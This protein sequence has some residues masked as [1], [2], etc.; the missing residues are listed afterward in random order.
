MSALVKEELQKDDNNAPLY[1][2]RRHFG[3]A[4]ESEAPYDVVIL[5]INHKHSLEQHI[6]K[7]HD[8][9]DGIMLYAPSWC[10]DIVT[11]ELWEVYGE[12]PEYSTEELEAALPLIA[13]C[14]S[15]K[16]GWDVRFK[17]RYGELPDAWTTADDLGRNTIYLYISHAIS[18]LNY[19]D[20]H[21][22]A[23]TTSPWRQD[24]GCVR[25]IDEICHEYGHTQRKLHH[26][27]LVGRTIEEYKADWVADAIAASG[28]TDVHALFEAMKTATGGKVNELIETSLCAPDALGSF[29]S[30]FA[31]QYGLRALYLLMAYAPQHYRE[32]SKLDTYVDLS[33]QA[34][35]YPAE[36]QVVAAL[37]HTMQDYS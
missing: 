27:A 28:Y 18:L 4:A 9:D 20:M 26:K 35:L 31:S 17:G 6:E 8:Y 24:M 1:K 36:N 37:I 23:H 2:V 11:E 3:I 16:R 32:T 21:K 13:I 19:I 12:D 29:L 22:E 14:E 5:N 15:N 33:H 34:T 10:K 25:D 7:L 30:G